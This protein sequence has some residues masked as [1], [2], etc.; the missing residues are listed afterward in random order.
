MIP[1]WHG[2]LATPAVGGDGRPD[3]ATPAQP[4]VSPNSRNRPAVDT[5]AES[6]EQHDEV[7]LNLLLLRCLQQ[8]AGRNAKIPN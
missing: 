3:H 7:R 4:E 1:V 6:V 8:Y 2:L 5:R